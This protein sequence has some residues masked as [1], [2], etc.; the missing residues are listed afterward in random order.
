MQNGQVGKS[1]KIDS[2]LV[3]SRGGVRDGEA[4]ERGD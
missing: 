4:W 1:T 2:R 3:V